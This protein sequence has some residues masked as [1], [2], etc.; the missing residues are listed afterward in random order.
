MHKQAQRKL[1]VEYKILQKMYQS[2][3][4]FFLDIASVVSVLHH[5]G[6]MGKR[7]LFLFF[8]ST[9]EQTGFMSGIQEIIVK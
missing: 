2:F 6:F 9:D 3:C 8:W 1:T 7:L 4:N 5:Q